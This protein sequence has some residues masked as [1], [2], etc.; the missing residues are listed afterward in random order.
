MWVNQNLYFSITQENLSK[1]EEIVKPNRMR[2]IWIRNIVDSATQRVL[3][4]HS[5]SC[6]NFCSNYSS[7]IVYSF[8]WNEEIDP[9]QTNFLKTH[10]KKQHTHKKRKK[11]SH[12]KKYKIDDDNSKELKKLKKRVSVRYMIS[13]WLEIAQITFVTALDLN[14][15][16]LYWRKKQRKAR[17][18]KLRPYK[19]D[20]IYKL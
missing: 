15:I 2:I 16:V 12:N 14:V 11:R 9:L 10:R 8:V 20:C 3:F 17:V 1:E 18:L 19:S 7:G 6:L 13:Y 5:A 4:I